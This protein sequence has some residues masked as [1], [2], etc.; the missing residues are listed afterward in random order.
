MWTWDVVTGRSYLTLL[1]LNVFQTACAPK[2]KSLLSF[3]LLFFNLVRNNLWCHYISRT[4]RKLLKTVPKMRYKRAAKIP[5]VVKLQICLDL[6]Q[7]IT[8]LSNCTPRH[9][10]ISIEKM[11]SIFRVISVIYVLSSGEWKH[12]VKSK[13]G[14]VLIETQYPPLNLWSLSRNVTSALTNG[15]RTHVTR[16]LLSSNILCRQL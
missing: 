9:T 1:R 16:T 7:C 6:E 10:T 3:Q 4:L 15:V 5:I 14:C 8:H 2:H 11:L 13:P 12:P